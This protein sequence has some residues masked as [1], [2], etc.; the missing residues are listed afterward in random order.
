MPSTLRRIAARFTRRNAGQNPGLTPATPPADDNGDWEGNWKD[1]EDETDVEAQP[2]VGHRRTLTTADDVGHQCAI[3]A[4]TEDG[5]QWRCLP[6][7]LTDHIVA[8]AP[9][10]ALH[11]LSLLERRVSEPTGKRLHQLCRKVVYTDHCDRRDLYWDWS[12]TET[13]LRDQLLWPRDRGDAYAVA[14]AALIPGL[15]KGTLSSLGGLV[16]REN[17]IGTAGA[18]ALAPA[19]ASLP[20]LVHLNLEQNPIGDAGTT[21]LATAI[22]DGAL[23]LLKELFLCQTGMGDAGATALATVLASASS[24]VLKELKVLSIESNQIGTTG[25]SALA[26]AV[27]DGAFP[28][29]V[30]IDQ[31]KIYMYN[32]PAI[33]KGN[34]TLGNLVAQALLR[35]K[36]APGARAIDALLG[37]VESAPWWRNF[38]LHRQEYLESVRLGA[39]PDDG[40]SDGW[41]TVDPPRLRPDLGGD[42][43]SVLAVLLARPRV[44]YVRA[45]MPMLFGDGVVLPDDPVEAID[46]AWD[47]LFKPAV[48]PAPGGFELKAA[49]VHATMAMLADV[50]TR[51][52]EDEAVNY[53]KLQPAPGMCTADL[54]SLLETRGSRRIGLWVIEERSFG[55]ELPPIDAGISIRI[56]RLKVEG[57]VRE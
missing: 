16:L 12:P 9:N 6:N 11:T 48:P 28:S 20:H 14:F 36:Y 43:Q 10:E 1:D 56:R 7:E 46:V 3:S 41:A 54:V 27:D 5:G 52:L 24:G 37:T 35:R 15:A 2:S 22:A 17:K 42:L 44:D 53:L 45:Y 39:L 25:M 8:L 18:E 38:A 23:P 55:L 49:Y 51:E 31:E 32:N 57:V 4:S 13:S 19:F 30:T 47:L 33:G 29:L 34:S 26:A 50:E 21:A 40:R